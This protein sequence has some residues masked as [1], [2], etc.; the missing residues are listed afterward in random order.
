ML[1]KTSSGPS[2]SAINSVRQPI[3]R[4]QCAPSM[5]FSSPMRAAPSMKLP[6]SL[7]AMRLL[8]QKFVQSNLFV[9]IR[10][11]DEDGLH[12]RTLTLALSHFA[13]EGMGKLLPRFF[14]KKPQRFDGRAVI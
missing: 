6:R 13:G 2:C 12:S 10:H 14:A 7:N 9:L 11:R 1:S 8:E 5:F 3:S 4:F